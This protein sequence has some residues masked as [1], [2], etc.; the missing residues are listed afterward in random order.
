ML[1]LD[2][3]RIDIEFAHWYLS[4]LLLTKGWLGWCAPPKFYAA[5][6]ALVG[7]AVASVGLDWRSSECSIFMHLF[8]R[9]CMRW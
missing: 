9:S 3:Q 1:L 6:M 7:V 2:I 5:N 8:F 4:D